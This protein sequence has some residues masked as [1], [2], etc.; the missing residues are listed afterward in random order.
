MQM[1]ELSKT[2]R[3]HVITSLANG[4]AGGAY[5]QPGRKGRENQDH[6]PIICTFGVPTTHSE[7]PAPQTAEMVCHNKWNFEKNQCLIS[8]LGDSTK[9]GECRLMLTKPLGFTAQCIIHSGG[10]M[11]SPS[12]LEPDHVKIALGG[13]SFSIR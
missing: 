2:N 13:G 6:G 11:A 3:S 1:V 9:V 12:D 8:R 5:F 4:R 7:L 10:A